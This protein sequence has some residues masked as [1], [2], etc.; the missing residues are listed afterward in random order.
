V[1][2]DLIPK[3]FGDSMV[4]V[5]GRSKLIFIMVGYGLLLIL[6]PST[7]VSGVFSAQT[8]LNYFIN[9]KSTEA[10]L[11]GFLSK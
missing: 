11:R 2:F 4:S 3:S 6:I 8:I 1:S 9:R 7:R 10:A 5:A